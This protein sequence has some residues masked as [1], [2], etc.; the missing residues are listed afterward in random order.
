MNT[1]ERTVTLGEANLDQS[2]PCRDC[3]HVAELRMTCTHC[4]YMVLKCWQC[5]DRLVAAT[6][7]WSMVRHKCGAQA[8][9]LSMIVRVIPL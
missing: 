6:K 5:F 4:Q 7:K 9:E 1:V 2:I 3:D 8:P